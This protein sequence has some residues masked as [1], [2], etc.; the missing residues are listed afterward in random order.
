MKVQKKEL[1]AVILIILGFTLFTILQVRC[2][3]NWNKSHPKYQM[4][5]QQ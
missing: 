5:N 4:S 3:D 2:V 1:L